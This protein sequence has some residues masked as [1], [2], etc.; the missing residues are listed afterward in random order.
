MDEYE[1]TVIR[2]RVAAGSKSDREAV[3]LRT[4]DEDLV[5]RLRGGNAFADPRLDALVGKRIR[6]AGRKTG[7][8]LILERWEEVVAAP[9]GR[10]P[11]K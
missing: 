1:G 7:Y 5:L 4:A 8:T 9:V 11:G 6:G 2:K 10:P 3:V